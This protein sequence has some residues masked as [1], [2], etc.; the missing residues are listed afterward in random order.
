MLILVRE[1][2]THI[3]SVLN[4]VTETCAWSGEH[5]GVEGS[6]CPQGR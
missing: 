3:I 2:V 1:S 6:F 4:M 5:R